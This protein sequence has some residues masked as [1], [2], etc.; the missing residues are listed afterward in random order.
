MKKTFLFVML[1]TLCLTITGCKN[2]ENDKPHNDNNISL[3]NSNES[4]ETE[5][6]LARK[7]TEKLSEYKEKT[8]TITDNESGEISVF[9][10]K[11]DGKIEIEIQDGSGRII[12]MLNENMLDE[13]RNEIINIEEGNGTYTIKV[14]TEDFVGDY[15]INWTTKNLEEITT[16]ESNEGYELQYDARKITSKGNVEG[17]D[18]FVGTSKETEDENVYFKSKIISADNAENTKTELKNIEG[19]RIG[20]CI[21]AKGT[22]K[23]FYV[24]KE[25]EVNGEKLKNMTFCVDLADG[26]IMVIETSCYDDN[27]SDNSSDMNRIDYMLDTIVIK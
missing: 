7:T 10:G 14:T 5:N 27:Y 16:F 13:N 8:F 6:R 21:L 1:I 22:L 19:A 3:G 17:Y 24:Q 26:K 23:G 4:I 18:Y 9:I 12:T 15:D 25:N 11:D 20:D 2:N